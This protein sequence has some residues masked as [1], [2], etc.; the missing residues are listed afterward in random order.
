[1]SERKAL[2][3]FH[4]AYIS[5]AEVARMES[6]GFTCIPT[7]N[8]KEVTVNSGNIIE[9]FEELTEKYVQARIEL[10]NLQVK[11]RKSLLDIISE[12]TVDDAS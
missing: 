6:L 11:S 8:P 1:M 10:N 5:E 3:F 4:P 2:V 12:R 7:E 9:A